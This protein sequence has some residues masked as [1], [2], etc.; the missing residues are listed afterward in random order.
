MCMVSNCKCSAILYNYFNAI[1]KIEII[2]YIPCGSICNN[3]IFSA[4]SW[5]HF[6]FCICDENSI[7]IF[8]RQIL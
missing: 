1:M 5:D 6:I 4:M 8:L 7:G 3:N 2:L